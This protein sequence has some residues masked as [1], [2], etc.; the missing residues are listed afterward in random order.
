MR[1]RLRACIPAGG[2]VAL[3]ALSGCGGNRASPAPTRAQFAARADA[4][5]RFEADKL[6]RAATIEHAPLAAFG[7]VP[8]LIRQAVV[9]RELTDARLEAL[10]VPAGEAGAIGRWLTARTV[11]ATLQRDAAEAPAGQFPKAT[12]DLD[13]ARAR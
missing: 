7:T 5:C 6:A 8:R 4:V 9:I 12:R 10:R 13:E 1:A 2:L 3:L 11:A